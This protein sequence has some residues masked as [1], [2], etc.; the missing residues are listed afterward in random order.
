MGRMKDIKPLIVALEEARDSKVLVYITGTKPPIFGTKVANDVLPLFKKILEELP[1]GTK[2][3]SLVLDTTGGNLDTPWPLVNLV[4]EYCKEFEVLVPEKALSA[5]TLIA[6]GADKIVMLPYSNLSPIDPA[7]EFI[8]AEKKQSKRIEIEDIIGYINFAK[9]KVGIK[10]QA[11]LGDV[12]KELGREIN[13]T[14]LGSAN[15]THSLIRSLAKKLLNLRSGPALK[16]W[17]VSQIVKHLSEDLFSHRH[18]I[19][20]KEAAESVGLGAMIETADETTKE[21]VEVLADFYTSY[22]ETEKAFDPASILGAD[23]EKSFKLPRAVVHSKD[24]AFSFISTYHLTKASGTTG[25][26]N[27]SVNNTLNSWEK[28]S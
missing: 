15:R 19:N 26:A 25:Q 21:A 6:L 8:D 28:V 7:A 10:D 2:K 20:R 9:E 3:I 27:I 14:M 22:L 23:T 24:L 17:Q 4:R 18:L 12:M 1:A 11:V 16:K 13:P 5:G